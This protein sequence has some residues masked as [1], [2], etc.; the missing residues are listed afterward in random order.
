MIFSYRTG[1]GACALVSALLGI[2]LSASVLA[3]DED[4]PPV[5]SPQAYAAAAG[6][7]AVLTVTREDHH[8]VLQSLRNAVVPPGGY[9]KRTNFE[10][11][12]P[13]PPGST[14]Q[15]D[16]AVQSKAAQTRN[17]PSL[18][19]NMDGVGNG[20]TGPQGTFTIQYAPPDTDGAVGFTQYVALVNTGLAVFDKT[21]GNVIYGPVPTNTLWSGFGGGCQSNN[22]GD[23]VVIYDRAANRWVI[24]QF[25]VSTTPYLQCVA[26]SQTSD[27]TGAWNRYSFNYGS[28]LFPDYPKMASWPDAYYETF[29]MFTGQTFS[30]G[31]LCAY[32]RTNMLAGNA[33]TQQC[34]SVS[35]YG[36]VLPSDLDGATAPPAG[37]P[38]YL[39]NYGTN[40]LNLWKFHVDWTTPANSTL[41]GPTA[42]S[43]ASF[44]PACGGGTCITQPG[45]AN[46][47]DSLADRMMFRLAYRNFGDHESLV[48]S[49]SVVVSTY[50]GVRW[51]EIRSPGTTPVVHQQSTFSPD[52]TF[53]WMPS[54]AMDSAGDIALGYSTSSSANS[55][56][57]SATYTGRTPA[58]ALGTMETEATLFAGTGSQSTRSLHRWGDYSAMTVDPIDDCTFWYTNEYIASNGSFNWNTRIGS[59]KFAGCVAAAYTLNYTS[60]S[61]GTISGTTPQA[62]VPAGSGTSVTAVPNAGYHF[63]QWSDSST[64]NPRTDTNV[65][66]SISVNAQFAVNVLVF[67]PTP[68]SVTQGNPLGTVTVTEQDGSSHTIVDNATVDFTLTYCSG[69]TLDLGMA[70]MSAGVAA[71]PTGQR[72]YNLIASSPQI[73]ASIVGGSPIVP[74]NASLSVTANGDI[75]F[76]DGFESCR[77]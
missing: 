38:N 71:L 34:Y 24:S 12:I 10:G 58:D 41:T 30:G 8:D 47:L 46:Q 5:M 16:G 72:F 35:G 77:P 20:F 39:I 64:A 62:V 76:P 11:L 18:I 40:Q 33:A 17:T 25:S 1:F 53:R 13:L 65:H 75:I 67:T 48:A 59:F 37:S 26:V 7:P 56:Y 70:T 23:G 42:I 66:A 6:T 36:G 4:T 43:V 14:D 21:T 55:V 61:N 9:G 60:D 3:K 51:Y 57:P 29:N 68:G 32:D 63:V 27:A 22:D 44:A 69:A 15:V 50:S 52:T 28:T 73:T 19:R 2:S 74:V 49:Q 45:T 54:I 31:N